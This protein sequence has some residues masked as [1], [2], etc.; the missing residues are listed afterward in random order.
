MN[1]RYGEEVGFDYDIPESLGKCQTL[2]FII[3]PLIENALIHGKANKG[4]IRVVVGEA[5]GDIVLR[6]TDSRGGMS[7][8]HVDELN[9]VI[10][11]QDSGDG[12]RGIGLL[13]VNKRIRLH[14]GDKYG[15]FVDSI[16]GT[17]TT[18]TVKIPVIQSGESVQNS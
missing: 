3:Q 2:R 9:R 17:G 5:G 4:V 18:V 1:Y 11:L 13:N 15:L 8:E 6:V 16:E 10:Q 14:F 7:Q 12:L